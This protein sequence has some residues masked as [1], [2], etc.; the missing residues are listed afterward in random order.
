M[1]IQEFQQT[2]SRLAQQE[3]AAAGLVQFHAGVAAGVYPQLVAFEYSRAVAA[4]QAK[5]A[6]EHQYDQ[7]S[8]D[9]VQLQLT[10]DFRPSAALAVVAADK[11]LAALGLPV[12]RRNT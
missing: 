12:P 2:A 7:D 11:L 8:A 10:L 6:E 1:N 9:E 4:A 5:Y 3:Q